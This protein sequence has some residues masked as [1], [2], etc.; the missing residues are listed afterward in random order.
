MKS[1]VYYQP[2]N[3]DLKDVAGDCVI[4]ALTKALDKTWA[5]VFDELVPIAREH[6]VLM[7]DK[8]CYE[9]LLAKYGFTYVGISNKKGSKRPTVKSFSLEHRND[10]TVY[11]LN[12]AHHC[13][14]VQGGFYY[15][16]W[17]CGEKCLYGYWRRN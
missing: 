16:I 6:Q 11:F 1:F 2:N 14:T 9:E 4:R 10:K 17:D 5:E 15:D 8:I 7:N 13:V 12:V 3:K